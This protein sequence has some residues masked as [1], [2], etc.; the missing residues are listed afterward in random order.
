MN[1]ALREKGYSVEFFQDGGFHAYW[2]GGRV[3]PECLKATWSGE[4][5]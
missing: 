2:S 4:V 3:L 5:K 1:A